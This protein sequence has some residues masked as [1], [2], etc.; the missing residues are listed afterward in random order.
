M[1]HVKVKWLMYDKLSIIGPTT[2]LRLI[3]AE[4]KVR[5]CCRLRGQTTS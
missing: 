3:N 5:L 2:L 1:A 4:V